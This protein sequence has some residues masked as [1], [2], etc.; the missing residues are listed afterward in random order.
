MRV[1]KAAKNTNTKAQTPKPKPKAP[2]QKPKK[3]EAVERG[4]GSGERGAEAA[5]AARGNGKPA[6]PGKQKQ[7]PTQILN[8]RW[9]QGARA[10]PRSELGKAAQI[11]NQARQ[12][13]GC[14]APGAEATRNPQRRR[15]GGAAVDP[16]ASDP[17]ACR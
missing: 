6:G 3:H 9:K 10:A 16:A 12:P 1:R 14:W 7:S 17:R 13:T 5:L 2:K 15:C 11:K 8:G 4:A